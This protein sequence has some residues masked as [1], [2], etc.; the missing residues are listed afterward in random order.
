MID[1]KD[2]SDYFYSKAISLRIS[3]VRG[4]RYEIISQLPETIGINLKFSNIN[5]I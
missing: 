4:L 3:L 5:L 2:I 1:K